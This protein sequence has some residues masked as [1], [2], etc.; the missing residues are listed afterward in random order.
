MPYYLCDDGSIVTDGIEI[1]DIR[2]GYDDTVQ[3]EAGKC[4]DYIDVCCETTEIMKE[5]SKAQQ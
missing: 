1:I 5:R 3:D 4:K 2:G